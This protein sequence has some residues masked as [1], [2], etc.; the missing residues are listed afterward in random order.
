[1]K[2]I[3]FNRNS[4]SASQPQQGNPCNRLD[5]GILK[6][7]KIPLFSLH[8]DEKEIQLKYVAHHGDTCELKKKKKKPPNQN[9]KATAVPVGHEEANLLRNF[10]QLQQKGC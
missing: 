8:Y 2:T 10:C 3:S 6:D 5:M 4:P 9:K 7:K 1:M